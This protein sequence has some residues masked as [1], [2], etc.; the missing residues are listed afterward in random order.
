MTLK[1]PN[2]FTKMLLQ[3]VLFNSMQQINVIE[4]YLIFLPPQKVHDAF[5]LG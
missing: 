1:H 2:S 5:C 4:V 3:I